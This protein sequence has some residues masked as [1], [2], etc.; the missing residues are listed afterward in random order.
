[1]T[2]CGLEVDAGQIV[3]WLKDEQAV[4]RRRRLEIRATR[5]YAAEPAAR[6]GP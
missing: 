1:M 6:R 5:E 2:E 4:H 3:D